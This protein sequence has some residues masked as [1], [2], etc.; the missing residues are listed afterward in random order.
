MPANDPGLRRASSR[1]GSAVRFNLG[2]EAI[3][4]ARRDV[5]EEQIRVAIEK[6]VAKAPPFT[7]EQRDR[8]VGLIQAATR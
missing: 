8:L 4:D 2:P 6:A 1:L 5:A 7:H 3:A